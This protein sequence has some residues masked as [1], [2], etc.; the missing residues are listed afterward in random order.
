VRAAESP[1]HQAVGTALLNLQQGTILV[2]SLP[3]GPDAL[4]GEAPEVA[5]LQHDVQRQARTTLL[6]PDIDGQRARHR[7]GLLVTAVD[8]DGDTPNIEL[9]AGC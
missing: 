1:A 4:G 3:H 8:A 7:A 6:T 5:M 2:G 9:L